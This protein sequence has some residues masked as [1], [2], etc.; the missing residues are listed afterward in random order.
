ME[1]HT[2]DLE[3]EGMHQAIAAF[4]VESG[5]TR[6]LIETGPESTRE[7]LLGKLTAL[8]CSPTELDA[9]F[10]THIH[11]D[12]A[13]AAGWF[14]KQGIPLYLHPNAERHIVD[15]TRLIESARMVY[16][17]Q[18]ENLWGGMTP[19][20]EE[21]VHAIPTG[22]IQTVGELSIEALETPGH[23][24]HHY[25]Y[26]LGNT[27]FAGDAAGAS[28]RGTDFISVTSAP[29][30]FHLTHTLNSIDLLKGRDFDEIYLTHFGSVTSPE[31]HLSDYRKA[32]ELNAEFI[33]QRLEERM[34]PESL[35][36]AYQAFC[37]EQAFRVETERETWKV[38]QSVNS[39]DMC[40][41]GIR[42]FWAKQMSEET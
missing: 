27:C 30:Q 17:D 9:V 24:F 6:I 29:P 18:F 13:G 36:I 8:G 35:K 40:A 4:L 5:E 38:L 11:L 20:P 15:P 41:E 2:I 22:S 10:V 25:A 42:L 37:M 23:A 34:D 28:I 26:A 12:H 14:A 19:A 33:R 32:V 39:T 31:Q 7:I 3:F 16:G 21:S 1:I